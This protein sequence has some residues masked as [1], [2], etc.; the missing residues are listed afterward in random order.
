MVFSHIPPPGASDRGVLLSK[1]SLVEIVR[2]P[3]W[4]ASYLIPCSQNFIWFELYD[5]V[6]SPIDCSQIFFWLKLY[7]PQRG[8]IIPYA[9]LSKFSLAEIIRPEYY[10]LQA[11]L[12]LGLLD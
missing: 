9:L 6:F 5:Q 7:N 8:C 10:G 4:E 11:G 12:P 3:R 1:F 2:P